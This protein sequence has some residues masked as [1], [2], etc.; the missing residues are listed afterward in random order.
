MKSKEPAKQRVL[1]FLRKQTK[2]HGSGWSYN[3]TEDPRQQAKVLHPMS[4]ILW[5]LELKID[6]QSAH[7]AR[8]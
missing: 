6:L 1:K 4:A 8:R 5:A 2:G 3:D 7:V